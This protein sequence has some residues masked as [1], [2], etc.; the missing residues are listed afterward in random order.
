MKRASK[1][2]L[3]A[4]MPAATIYVLKT[5]LSYSR[6]TRRFAKNQYAGT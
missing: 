4:Q 5:E 3:D 1:R 2:G 6:R